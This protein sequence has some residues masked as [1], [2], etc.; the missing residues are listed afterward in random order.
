M[1]DGTYGY[2][3]VEI[4]L[5]R[6]FRAPDKAQR[7][8][9]FRGRLKHLQRLGLPIEGPGTGKKASYTAEMVDDWALALRMEEIGIEPNLIVGLINGWIGPRQATKV[10]K[11]QLAEYAR[12]ARRSLGRDDD[13]VLTL[14]SF[15]MSSRWTGDEYPAVFRAFKLGELKAGGILDGWLAQGLCISSFNLS[16]L[17]RNLDAELVKAAQEKQDKTSS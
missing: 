16:E 2:Q 15:F 1:D 3:V 9:V 8:G 10:R 13:T 7:E 5:A 12:R 4:A 6:L 11:R 14:V 17:L